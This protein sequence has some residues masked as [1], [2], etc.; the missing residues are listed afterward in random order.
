LANTYARKAPRRVELLPMGQGGLETVQRKSD[1]I[2]VSDEY[3]Q[4]I[5]DAKCAYL[6]EAAIA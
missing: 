6:I 4:V 1:Y 2:Q 5:V 3:D